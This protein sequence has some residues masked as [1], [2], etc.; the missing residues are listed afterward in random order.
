MAEFSVTRV[1]TLSVT[2]KKKKKLFFTRIE[3][4]TS[5]L[6]AGVRGYLLNHTGDEGYILEDDGMRDNGAV[7]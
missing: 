6:L 5:A 7:G 3:L 2:E 4:T 1:L